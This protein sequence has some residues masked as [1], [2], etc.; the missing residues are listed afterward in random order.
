[1]AIWYKQ[2][3]RSFRVLKKPDFF[4]KSGFSEKPVFQINGELVSDGSRG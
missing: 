2:A 1:M 3:K 4:E